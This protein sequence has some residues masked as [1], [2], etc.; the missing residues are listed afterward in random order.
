MYNYIKV[1]VLG[2]LSVLFLSTASFSADL[3][4]TFDDLNPG[5]KAAFENAIAQF[6]KENPDINVIAN[7][8][9]RE[10]HKAAIRNFLIAD[11]PDAVAQESA[12]DPSVFNT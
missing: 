11:A 5:P 6:Q 4:I 10:E 1:T 9:D 7:N 8:G 2:F 3:V 12:P